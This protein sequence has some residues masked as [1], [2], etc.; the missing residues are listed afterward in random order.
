MRARLFLNGDSC[1]SLSDY[2]PF[3][4]SRP[5]APL[6]GQWQVVGSLLLYA[7]LDRK[8]VHPSTEPPVLV[9]LLKDR[10]QG[11][12]L[13]SLHFTATRNE[14][15]TVGQLDAFSQ[16]GLCGVKCHW[17]LR[18]GRSF[19]F[20]ADRPARMDVFF[21]FLLQGALFQTGVP[22]ARYDVSGRL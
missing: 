16:A 15:H 6:G 7:L 14:S 20:S 5:E 13:A 3:P 8:F 2:V 9:R 18:T 19:A 1:L 17:N 11:E 12:N 21:F 22:A 10:Q 4:T